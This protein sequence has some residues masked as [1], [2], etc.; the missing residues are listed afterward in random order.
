MAKLSGDEFSDLLTARAVHPVF[1]AI[2][3]LDD[4]RPVGFEA[5]ARGPEGSRYRS[6]AALFAEAA[7]RG[8]QAHLDW[9]CANAAFGCALQ[10][11]LEVPL[12]VNVDP[13]TIGTACPLDLLPTFQ[14]ALRDLNLVIEITERRGGDPEAMLRLVARFR[15]AGGRIA[16]DDV[17]VDPLSMNV[18]S[19]LA[20]DVIKLDRSVTQVHAPSWART[21]LINAVQAEARAGGAAVLCEGI[22]TTEHLQT[23]RSLGATLGQGWLFG[24]PGPLPATIDVSATALP[25]VS[26]YPPCARTPFE[27]IRGRQSTFPLTLRAMAP[28]KTLLAEMA[29]RTDAANMMFGLLPSGTDL[30]DDTRMAFTHIAQRG[31]TVTVFGQ[32]PLSFPAETVHVV[33]LRDGDPLLDEYAFILVG[34]YFSAAFIACRTSTSNTSPDD[35]LWDTKLTYDRR[36]VIEAAHSLLSRIP[37]VP[38]EAPSSDAIWP[39]PEDE[40]AL[41]LR[42]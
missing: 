34:S 19:V 17:G 16:V 2:V 1:Q 13:A 6:P 15:A 21:R 36:T 32:A 25:R 29:E 28:V 14:R 33:R 9:V 4:E 10:A 42:S 24:K 23:A 26:P 35:Q 39:A 18:I 30:D 41:H 38:A 11:E 27:V 40:D 8:E 12:F 20:P 31:V 37:A 5:L 7:R 3:S 22:E